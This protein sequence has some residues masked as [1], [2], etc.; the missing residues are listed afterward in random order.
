MAFLTLD[1]TDIRVQTSG[2]VENEPT[3]IGE[4]ARAFDG[5]YRSGVRAAK[6]TWTFTLASGLVADLAAIKTLIGLED[7]LTATGEFIGGETIDVIAR[8]GPVPYSPDGVTVRR[9]AT[10]TVIEK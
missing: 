5:S 9:A 3:L 7:T 10:L 8:L 4:S 6:R 1:G 2:A